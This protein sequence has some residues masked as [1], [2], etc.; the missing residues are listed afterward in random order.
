[1][2]RNN[3]K[4]QPIAKNIFWIDIQKSDNAAHDKRNYHL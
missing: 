1:M 2:Y 3:F 4:L